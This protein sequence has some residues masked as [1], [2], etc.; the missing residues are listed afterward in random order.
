MQYN[1]VTEMYVP[2]PNAKN[3]ETYFSILVLCG[4]FMTGVY[5][6]P[7]LLRPLDFI[8]NLRSYIVGL[9]VYIFMMPTFVNVMQI[10]AMCNLDDVSWGNRP[11]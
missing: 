8:V 7:I 10:F 5:L 4:I 2:Y 6:I 9:I 3:P 11:A 1:N